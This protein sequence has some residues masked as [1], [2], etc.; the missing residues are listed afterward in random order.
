MSSGWHTRFLRIHCGCLLSLKYWH[1]LR[2]KA[3]VCN[4]KPKAD[5]L[6]C[7]WLYLVVHVSCFYK[8]TAPWALFET[9]RST[10]KW[11]KRLWHLGTTIVQ[12]WGSG[13]RVIEVWQAWGGR[14]LALSST[15]KLQG[16]LEEKQAVSSEEQC[17]IES[18]SA[19]RPNPC[20][21]AMSCAPSCMNGADCLKFWEISFHIL[22]MHLDYSSVCDNKLTLLEQQRK[23]DVGNIHVKWLRLQ[24]QSYVT[25]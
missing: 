8:K 9:I 11:R 6:N 22:I 2:T 14:D 7:H 19:D 4:L 5:F 16:E 3:A 21:A 1:D 12:C 17:G 13:L 18:H 10:K 24:L 20:A 25:L 15:D 23:V